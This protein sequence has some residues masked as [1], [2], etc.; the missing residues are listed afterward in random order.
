VPGF[1]VFYYI[2]LP[3][4]LAKSLFVISATKGDAAAALGFRKNGDFSI[5]SFLVKDEIDEH[6]CAKNNTVY[7]EGGKAMSP[8][9][10]H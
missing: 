2:F 1:L 3:Q 9:K 8:H 7:S 4:L 5:E 6:N 10:F